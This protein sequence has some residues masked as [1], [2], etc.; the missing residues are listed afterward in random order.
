MRQNKLTSLK[1]QML[2]TTKREQSSTKFSLQK[3]SKHFVMKLLWQPMATA[4]GGTLVY[5]TA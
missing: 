5:P 1:N 2:M 4:F 3:I